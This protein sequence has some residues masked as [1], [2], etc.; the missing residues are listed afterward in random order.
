MSIIFVMAVFSCM[1]RRYGPAGG[2]R[3]GISGHEKRIIRAGVL[4]VIAVIF[5]NMLIF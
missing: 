5:K 1:N 3:R 2:H 4:A